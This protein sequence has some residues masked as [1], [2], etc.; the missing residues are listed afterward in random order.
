MREI[1]FI[2]NRLKGTVLI[3]D[4]QRRQKSA[5]SSPLIWAQGGKTAALVRSPFCRP[6]VLLILKITN[7]LSQTFG[8]IADLLAK[9]F[10]RD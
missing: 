4:N 1:S 2:V 6:K 9:H 7:P 8:V 3:E 10:P 5:S